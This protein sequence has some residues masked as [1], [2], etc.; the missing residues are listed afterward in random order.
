[1]ACLSCSFSEGQRGQVLQP[2]TQPSWKAESPVHAHSWKAE[3]PV[4]AC[5]QDLTP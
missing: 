4:D 5:M 1:M 3:S 2:S